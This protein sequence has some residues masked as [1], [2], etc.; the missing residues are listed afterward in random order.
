LIASLDLDLAELLL[1]LDQ[2]NHIQVALSS[3]IKVQCLLLVVCVDPGEAIRLKLEL[4][5]LYLNLFRH[6]N[7]ASCLLSDRF[8]TFLKLIES[9]LE[10]NIHWLIH[11]FVHSDGYLHVIVLC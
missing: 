3:L 10:D 8:H 11:I 7:L 1:R 4:S 5:H 2:S 6:E 9:F